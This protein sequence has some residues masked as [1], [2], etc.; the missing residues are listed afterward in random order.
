LMDASTLLAAQQV[1]FE[2]ELWFAD[3]I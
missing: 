3:Q 2:F 1:K